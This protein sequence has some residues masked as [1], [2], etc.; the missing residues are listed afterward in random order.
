MNAMT[1]DHHTY[2][3]GE[4]ADILDCS[5]AYVSRRTKKGRDVKSFPAHQFAVTDGTGKLKHFRIPPSAFEGEEEDEETGEAA[6]TMGD[7]LD[8][9]EARENADVEEDQ[10][11]NASVTVEVNTDAAA[12]QSDEQ[13]EE[14][15][16]EQERQPMP[17]GNGKSAPS[18]LSSFAALGGAVTLL[19]LFGSSDKK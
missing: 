7:F 11:E 10:R 19:G 12:D 8:D 5:K 2:T 6:Q 4:M 1:S 13:E 14:N 3:L 16:E 17:N 9:A 18:L 15:E